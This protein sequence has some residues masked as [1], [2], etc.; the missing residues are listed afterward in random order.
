MVQLINPDPS[1]STGDQTTK[2]GWYPTASEITQHWPE[3]KRPYGDS[4]PVTIWQWGRD[5]LP[6]NMYPNFVEITSL[7]SLPL[8][9]WF[10]GLLSSWDDIFQMGTTWRLPNDPV[11]WAMLVVVVLFHFH[12]WIVVTCLVQTKDSF[13]NLCRWTCFRYVLIY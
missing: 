13:K 10:S 5:N 3:K 7:T 12:V 9:N 1:E 11:N 8:L 4:Y 2:G 6:R